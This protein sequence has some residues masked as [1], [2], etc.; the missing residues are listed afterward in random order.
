MYIYTCIQATCIR[1]SVQYSEVTVGV[2]VH[3][4]QTITPFKLIT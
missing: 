1:S 3:F 4:L 2:G